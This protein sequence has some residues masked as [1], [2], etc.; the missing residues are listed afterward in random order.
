MNSKPK[1]SPEYRAKLRRF[2]QLRAL[3]L[4]GITD[5]E[6]AEMDALAA[7]LDAAELA[8]DAEPTP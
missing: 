2:N 8:A 7:W 6:R 5:E 4:R 3:A 1:Q